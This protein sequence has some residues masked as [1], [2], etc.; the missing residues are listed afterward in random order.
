MTLSRQVANAVRGALSVRRVSK[1]RSFR[2]GS[3]VR[4]IDGRLVVGDRVTILR[5]GEFSGAVTIGNRVFVNRD[6]YIRP[7]VTIGDDVSLGPFVRLVTDSHVIAGPS[8]RAGASTH[9][10]I[11]IGDGAW[12]G[13][14]VTVLPGVRIGDGAVVAAGSTVTRDVQPNTLVAGTPA[15]LVRE[16]DQVTNA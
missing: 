8:R 11:R 9:S 15:R 1:G 10:P 6:A 5:N 2:R 16:L 12:L 13:A 14:G 3:S 4:I 7:G